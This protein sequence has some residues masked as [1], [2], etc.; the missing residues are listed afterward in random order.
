MSSGHGEICQVQQ[1][2]QADCKAASSKLLGLRRQ[3]RELQWCCNEHVEQWVDGDS[4]IADAGGPRPRRPARSSRWGTMELGGEDNDVLL[5]PA[6]TAPAVEH[7]AS[8]DHH[9]VAAGPGSLR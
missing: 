8:A 7:P 4:Q 1:L 9:A 5:R 3:K 2:G 6:W